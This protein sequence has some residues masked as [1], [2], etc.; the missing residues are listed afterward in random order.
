[1]SNTSWSPT[2]HPNNYTD[3]EIR[4]ISLFQ[5]LRELNQELTE[6]DVIELTRENITRKWEAICEQ[7]EADLVREIDGIF[8]KYGVKENVITVNRSEGFIKAKRPA[9][10]R[11]Q[12]ADYAK[13][14]GQSFTKVHASQTNP[15]R[16]GTYTLYIEEPPAQTQNYDK[17][18]VVSL[19]VVD[20]TGFEVRYPALDR[21]KPQVNDKFRE[22]TSPSRLGKATRA[23]WA[24]SPAVVFNLRAEK[25]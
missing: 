12:P 7:R 9:A 3:D 22:V 5:A 25:N 17:D 18:P 13:L 6:D 20:P 14:I 11:F 4:D 21:K 24:Q 2:K 10:K 19:R 1:M 16:N 23:A 15:D 8:Q